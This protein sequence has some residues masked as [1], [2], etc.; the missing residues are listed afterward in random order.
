M[1]TA[2]PDLFAALVDQP[3]EQLDLAWYDAAQQLLAVDHTT[4]GLSDRVSVALRPIVARG[5]ALGASGLVLAHNHPSGC[6]EPSHQDYAFTRRLAQI[7][8]AL[9]ICLNDHVILAKTGR[10][11]FRAAGLL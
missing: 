1:E 9:D 8:A 7:L 5:L 11:S 10:F 6:P 4:S 2:A 3:H